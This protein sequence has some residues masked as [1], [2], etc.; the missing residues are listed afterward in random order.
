MLDWTT[1]FYYFSVLNNCNNENYG[2]IVFLL[3][4]GV[5]GFFFFLVAHAF[6]SFAFKLKY[7]S[8]ISHLGGGHYHHVLSPQERLISM[9]P[10][11]A[12][13]LAITMYH[14]QVDFCPSLKDVMLYLL[15]FYWCSPLLHTF[16]RILLLGSSSSLDGSVYGVC[17]CPSPLEC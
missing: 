17:C 8:E 1:A 6:R 11:L 15:L 5:R 12:L 4:I 13:S 16:C 2:L 10:Q 3:F 9:A 7:L 14:G